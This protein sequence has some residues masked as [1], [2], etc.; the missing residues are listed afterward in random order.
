[1][2]AQGTLPAARSRL[3][4]ILA[5]LVIGAL[6][7]FT[8]YVAGKRNAE[9][10][11]ILLTATPPDMERVALVRDRP[12]DGGRCQTLWLGEATD[13]VVEILQLSGGEKVEE[14]A[15]SADGSLV[16]F[17]VNGY[18]LRVFE[19]ESRLPRATVELFKPDGI[20]SRHIARGITFSTNGAA[21]TYDECPRRTSGCKSGLS[22]VR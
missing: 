9:E 19:A 18:Q 15:F 21:V 8:G 20:P 3:D 11:R 13:K 10:H 7:G 4:V 6:A 1:M 12:C 2:S 22:P 16:G 14:I 5:S 17:L